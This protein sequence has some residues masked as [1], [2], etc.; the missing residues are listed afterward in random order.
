MAKQ[1]RK[2]SWWIPLALLFMML[3]LLILLGRDGLPDWANE[4]AGLGIVLMLFAGTAL[5]FRLSMPLFLDEELE[6]AKHEE[7]KI[8][9]YLP[10]Q[11]L[12]RPIGDD[13]SV[14][15]SPDLSQVNTFGRFRN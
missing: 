8:E 4:T 6:Q 14:A 12:T 11:P 7:I 15:V 9:E 2:P 1:K 3:A 13:K 10:G 5:W